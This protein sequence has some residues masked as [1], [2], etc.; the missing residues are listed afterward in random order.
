MANLNPR[1]RQNLGM[2]TAYGE[3]YTTRMVHAEI[4]RWIQE[5]GGLENSLA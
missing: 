5:R 4:E 3:V 1:F 2:Q